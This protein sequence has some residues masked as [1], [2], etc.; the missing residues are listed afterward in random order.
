MRKI[1]IAL[2]AGIMLLFACTSVESKE[3]PKARLYKRSELS[4]L[5]RQMHDAAKE[6][7][8][9]LSDTVLR[10][11]YKQLFEEIQ[12]ATPSDIDLKENNFDA[13]AY[14]WQES[15]KE[16]LAEKDKPAEAFNRMVDQCLNCHNN[17]CPGPIPK[18]KRL[19]IKDGA[20]AGKNR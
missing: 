14:A 12:S 2:A 4:L 9:N 11:E 16:M 7:K 1:A 17:R 13:F 3:A 10:K 8:K 20:K 5:M 19:K 18:I 6:L 15:W